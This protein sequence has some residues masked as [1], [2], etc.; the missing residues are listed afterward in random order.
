MKD[1]Q[2]VIINGPFWKAEAKIINVT[3]STGI[4][5][6]ELLAQRF[7]NFPKNSNPTDWRDTGS[8]YSLA[9][10]DYFSTKTL[11]DQITFG[12]N[13][14][15]NNIHTHY[16]TPE[17]RNWT[18]YIFTGQLL[19]T[20]NKSGVGVTFFSLYGENG[21]EKYYRLK[22]TASNQGEFVLD[23]RQ[24][25][26]RGT[27]KSG[28]KS[29]VNTWYSFKIEVENTADQTNIR[30]KI[31]ESENPE[32]AAYQINAFD[33]RTAQFDPTDTTSSRITH[34]TVGF[35]TS[36]AGAKHF[37]NLKVIGLG[38]LKYHGINP[39]FTDMP[40]IST[41]PKKYIPLPGTVTAIC[42]INQLEIQLVNKTL[43]WIRPPQNQLPNPLKEAAIK[44]YLQNGELSILLLRTNFTA[45]NANDLPQYQCLNGAINLSLLTPF[46]AATSD[47]YQLLNLTTV[48]ER[49]EDE[50]AKKLMGHLVADA[51]G[52]ALYGGI[53][54]PWLPKKLSAPFRLSRQFPAKD[55]QLSLAIEKLTSIEHRI[56]VNAWQTLSAFVNPKFPKNTLADT[57]GIDSAKWVT[58][59]LSDFEAVP[60]IL[61]TLT[62]NRA[63]SR[64]NNKLFFQKGAFTVLMTDQ[65]VYSTVQTPN[66]IARIIPEL[67]RM[68][69]GETE[70]K[71]YIEAG[72][73]TANSSETIN[74]Q[75]KK[76]A[77]NWEEAIDCSDL[78][79]AYNAVD[80][81]RQLNLQQGLPFPTW[82]GQKPIANPLVWGFMPLENGWAQLPIVNL[83]EQIY[84][85]AKIAKVNELTASK[86][87]LRGVV[88]FGNTQK[89]NATETPSNEQA[90]DISIINA[91]SAF[92]VWTLEKTP[93]HFFLLKN[94]SLALNAPEVSINGLLWLSTEQ[95]TAQD[96]LPDLN[97][98]ITGLQAIPLKSLA[99]K[100]RLFIPAL[101]FKLPKFEFQPE[102][103][104]KEFTSPR[105]GNWTLQYDIVANIFHQLIAENII[106]PNLL[107]TK[108]L[109]W[110]RHPSLPMVQAMPMTQS[111]LPPNAPIASRQLVPFELPVV[112]ENGKILP[113]SW[114]FTTLGGD[115]A[116][117]WPICNADLLPATEWTQ[118][119]DLPLVA[120]SLPGLIAAPNES[121]VGLSNFLPL[122]LR[123]DLPYMDEINAFAQLTNTPEK[124]NN[125]SPLPDDLAAK[126]PTALQRKDLKNHWEK[127]AQLA[128]LS[129][130]ADVDAFANTAK[131][132]VIQNLV[133]PLQWPVEAAMELSNY[134]GQLTLQ[135]K[136]ATNG[137]E[138]ILTQE[139]ALKGISGAFLQTNDTDLE[140]VDKNTD[141]PFLIEA[142][143][144]LAWKDADEGLLRDQ[145]GLN[146][147]YT[148]AKDGYLQTKVCQSVDQQ[149]IQLTTTL[150]TISLQIGD[151]Q[152]W[153]FWFKDLPLFEKDT[154]TVFNRAETRSAAAIDKDVNDPEALGSQYNYLQGYE[155]RLAEKDNA[156]T[157]KSFLQLFQLHFFPLTLDQVKFDTTGLEEIVITGK[158]QL[159]N[160]PVTAIENLNNA[161][162]LVYKKQDDQLSLQTIRRVAG[163]IEW[164]LAPMGSID[165]AIPRICWDEIVLIKNKKKQPL[166]QIKRPIVKMLLFD[167]AWSIPL[168]PLNLT[169]PLSQ[170]TATF[171]RITALAGINLTK[172]D[173][174]LDFEHFNHALTLDLNVRLGNRDRLAFVGDVRFHLIGQKAG[175]VEQL[176]N[177]SFLFKNLAIQPLANEAVAVS[178]QNLAFQ[179]KWEKLANQHPEESLSDLQVLPG[180]HLKADSNSSMPGYAVLT[181]EVFPQVAETSLPVFRLKSAFVESLLTCAWGTSLQD[182]LMEKKGNVE[183]V[184][185]ASAGDLIFGLTT[186]FSE[187]AWKELYNLNGFL[188]IKNTLSWP[189]N[190]A[191]SPENFLKIPALSESTAFRH[192][193]HGISILLNQHEIPAALLITNKEGNLLFNLD[194]QS[195][196]Q[197]LAVTEHQL[198]EVD[199]AK[200][201]ANEK[202]AIGKEIR[203]TAVQ[204]I[205]FVHTHNYKKFLG[206]LSGQSS[207]KN[208]ETLNGSFGKL[209]KNLHRIPASFTVSGQVRN[210]LGRGIY[211]AKVE[212]HRLSTLPQSNFEGFLEAAY[213]SPS[214]FFVATIPKTDIGINA[215][216]GV[217]I[218]DLYFVVRKEGELLFHSKQQIH[219]SFDQ[220]SQS[221]YLEIE[222]DVQPIPYMPHQMAKELL[223]V[224]EEYP[225]PNLLLVEA[226]TPFWVKQEAI[227]KR[228]ISTLQVLPSGTQKGLLSSL[229]D[230]GVSDPTDPKWQLLSL[231]FLGRL[232]ATKIAIPDSTNIGIEQA[233]VLDPILHLQQLQAKNA[234]IPDLLL[235]FTALAKEKNVQLPFSVIQAPTI[236]RWARLDP[237]SLEEN[238]FRLLNPRN[239]PQPDFLPPITT[240]L[241]E[242]P[243]KLSRA[244]TL[245]NAFVA[246][247][248]DYPPKVL[249]AAVLPSFGRTGTLLWRENSIIQFPYTT[250]SEWEAIYSWAYFGLP[251]QSL[252][253]LFEAPE[254]ANTTQLILPATTIL[255]TQELDADT[256]LPLSFVISPYLSLDFAKVSSETVPKVIIA[257][258]LCQDGKNQQLLP[259]SSYMLKIEDFDSITAAKQ[260]LASW[261]Q[262]VQQR[263][264]PNS[265]IGILRYREIRE[266]PNPLNN[267]P[268]IAISYAF[269]WVAPST[270]NNYAK[271][272]FNLRSKVNTLRFQ[273]GQFG[274]NRMPKA[275]KTFELAP[276]Q[277]NGIQP[278]YLDQDALPP[279]APWG[280]ATTRITT[281][282][283]KD[284]A[285][286][287]G[288]MPSEDQPN[289]VLWWQALQHFVQFR[290]FQDDRP[291]AGLPQHFRAAAI[292]SLLPVIPDLPLPELVLAQLTAQNGASTENWQS[293]LPGLIQTLPLH[294]RAGV[295]MSYRQMLQKQSITLNG[296]AINQL[297][298][299]VSGSIPVQHRTPRPVPLPP[300]VSTNLD[301]ALQPWSSRFQPTQ[302]CAFNNHPMDEAFFSKCAALKEDVGLKMALLKPIF[303]AIT[304]GWNGDLDFDITTTPNEVTLTDWVIK[305]E[306]IVNNQLFTYKELVINDNGLYTFNLVEEAV[307][308]GDR[309]DS[310]KEIFNT[311]PI[312]TL[313]YLQFK[314]RPTN[315]SEGFYQNL[316]FPLRIRATNTLSLPLIPQFIHFEDPAYNRQ[317]ASA[318][319]HKT[320]SGKIGEEIRSVRLSTDRK[321]Y[322]PD[323]S[324]AFRVDSDVPDVDKAN[325]T[326]ALTIKRVDPLSGALLTVGIPVTIAENKLLEIDLANTF[327][328]VSPLRTGDGLQLS[329][330]YAIGDTKILVALT[331]EIVANPIAPVPEAA[332]GLLRFQNLD[333]V[334]VVDCARFA[335]SPN[336]SRVELIC[337]DDLLSEIVRRRAVFNWTDSVRPGNLLKYAIQK[338]AGNGSTHFPK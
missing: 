115:G 1:K 200:L 291:R 65:S 269:D 10:K 171:E 203:W 227:K 21:V 18:N 152:E 168:P 41:V 254:N 295:Y 193:R 303:G 310:L 183:A 78:A 253:E 219:W 220:L 40:V 6:V 144:M 90:W 311:L 222:E 52:L 113:D 209:I 215:Q 317:L 248:L 105:L 20:N 166:L 326:I 35:W 27:T 100:E 76:T 306:F 302:N 315:G 133:Q 265:P 116:D 68:E 56:W 173:L 314:V 224:L 261:A 228:G 294:T 86:K 170:T 180:I 155:W 150:K 235:G 199:T 264:C 138:V 43:L 13:A 99:V 205:R 331:L 266:N 5:K 159:P 95:P 182:N 73:Q 325:A 26:I 243:A 14:T 206:Y 273:E 83:T 313:F 71:I 304:Q 278:I 260:A 123:Y 112:N 240:S 108:A 247:R 296:Q 11:A 129:S 225:Q 106:S 8:A 282:Y 179:F 333:A 327:K 214:G 16:N 94:I 312:G 151:G 308:N 80:T 292:K 160:S 216:G 244:T 218:P 32:P 268:P 124:P 136:G 142:N 249:D 289:T 38:T 22:R 145:R 72:N 272:V 187:G 110:Q 324:I 37:D 256:A 293:I 102:T 226:S 188:E 127:L 53:N 263:L 238:W 55:Y 121:T 134:P 189:I 60:P 321:I 301:K 19:F 149:N 154:T 25:V 181:F 118:A 262:E 275:A 44:T 194:Q 46:E 246:K 208:T 141:N 98:W 47:L 66:T 300:N 334:P 338:I 97:N 283:T 231:P 305:G 217:V 174:N 242:S 81:P 259:A 286:V 287:I 212:I 223:A 62:P 132:L 156:T 297:D 42:E 213:T 23:G 241:V 146:R 3:R 29:K 39:L 221:I 323:S 257:E 332:Y 15:K 201:L 307:A 93:R 91:E 61:W 125:F 230:Y 285:A 9:E 163:S 158:L 234:A 185:D 271:K 198:L 45:Q 190:L 153:E 270:T 120:L 279:N 202:N 245:T 28:V 267:E 135:N 34:G 157:P 58:L 48:F 229:E 104:S 236:N 4:R 178:Y 117:S 87:L 239:E 119:F 169:T 191:L 175:T 255:P 252:F 137:L 84:L 147:G 172:I 69:A 64:F 109:I 88:S 30:A 330:A 276:P 143:S 204:E 24:T 114:T 335:W 57:T 192:I 316:T 103:D 79:L 237:H 70:I 328:A 186:Q 277:V 211:N 162:Q 329:I 50:G 322:N 51:S 31:W 17:S 101:Q 232:Q 36:K 233:L 126:A 337:P 139:Q 319:G 67:V 274:G 298:K 12:T 184:F 207:K 107:D 251:L 85:D 89:I 148:I 54:L 7:S 122:Q 197:F 318:S 196:W 280:I 75:A 299:L 96:A 177:T 2:R 130:A 131:G 250:L 49:L 165:G 309:Q 167:I 284:Q 92:G 161:V 33:N 63:N 164:P 320:V 140:L 336:A 281:Q 77:K 258:L 195:T 74:Y 59:E 176:K 82:D 111:Q 128:N 288:S 290:E 210:V